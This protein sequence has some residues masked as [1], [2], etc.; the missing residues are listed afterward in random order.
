MNQ[1]TKAIGLNLLTLI[2]GSFIGILFALINRF[3]L[4][5]P[6]TGTYIFSGCNFELPFDRPIFYG[7]FLRFTSLKLSLWLTI[8]VQS[9]LG[10]FLIQEL[11]HRVFSE[12]RNKHWITLG[13]I[14]LLAL[15]SSYSYTVSELI[16]DVFTSYLLLGMIL[17]LYKP[18]QNFKQVFILLLFCYSILTHNSHL[19]IVFGSLSLLFI[20]SYFN[21]LLQRR[22]I[23]L[24]GLI[25]LFTMLSQLSFNYLKH[26][27]F[28]LS[29]VTNTFLF[30]RMLQTGAVHQYINDHP[31]STDIINKNIND[32][33]RNAVDF[34][35]DVDHS[36]LYCDS[37]LPKKG[38]E[39]CWT[40]K[41]GLFKH[42]IKRV[43]LYAPSRNTYLKELGISFLHQ[44]A[45]YSVEPL[46][47]QT[48]DYPVK[49][50][51][52]QNMK[53]DFE[54]YCNSIQYHRVLMFG[55][56]NK[57]LL[58]TAL[59]GLVIVI[60]GIFYL[61]NKYMNLIIGIYIIF[62]L[63]NSAICSS[64]SITTERYSSRISWVFILLALIMVLLLFIKLRQRKLAHSTPPKSE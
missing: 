22:Q 11:I 19:L 43:L 9:F 45:F 47:P 13:A 27:G 31:D 32:I 40:E 3:P 41:E 18:T 53:F 2:I 10:A 14:T 59:F 16:A 61:R 64:L 30:A 15:G 23:L 44:T 49:I 6:D 63:V 35:W 7:L 25:T 8:L 28:K 55:T 51:V 58:Y 56:T 60:F 17:W 57:I 50:N 54:P 52:K 36:V 12:S 26:K 1:N 4:V 5:Y 20:W 21:P 24:L 39:P 37:C 33:P 42:Y 29:R 62:H 46:G 38:W 48:T 34:L